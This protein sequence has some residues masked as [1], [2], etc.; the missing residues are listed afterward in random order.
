MQH[1]FFP[2][3]EDEDV[4]VEAEVQTS[5][6]DI[7]E[8]NRWRWSRL[9][10]EVEVQTSFTSYP[11][12][13]LDTSSEADAQIQTSFSSI[14]RAVEAQ[15]QTSFFSLRSPSPLESDA[16]MQTSFVEVPREIEAQVQTSLLSLPEAKEAQ[17]QTS[18]LSFPRGGSAGSLKKF[19]QAHPPYLEYL[20]KI[21]PYSA[22][23]DRQVQTA[24][25]DLPPSQVDTQV[26]T[27][28]PDYMSEK[29]D[30]S[31]IHT[32]EYLHERSSSQL[33]DVDMYPIYT[34]AEVQTLPVEIPPGNDWRSSRLRAAAQ[35]QTS[36]C[37]VKR[38]SVPRSQNIIQVKPAKLEAEKADEVARILEARHASL[39]PELT[40]AAIQTSDIQLQE[41]DKWCSPRQVNAQVQTST[42][43][44]LKK[45]SLL[46]Q[47]AK[48]D[49]MDAAS[50][51]ELL[52]KMSEVQPASPELMR[53]ASA[54]SESA[55]EDQDLSPALLKKR[56]SSAQVSPW[57]YELAQILSS[58]PRTKDVEMHTTDAQ[59]L[60]KRLSH[61]SLT[62]VSDESKEEIT[63]QDIDPQIR[64]WY[65]ELP[66][67][68]TSDPQG[69]VQKQSLWSPFVENEMQ[70][71]YI[72]MPFRHKWRS[73]HMQADHEVQTDEFASPLDE[74]RSSPQS[75]LQRQASLLEVWQARD[76]AE[77]HMQ[78]SALDVDQV[79][80]S[81]QEESSS[82][83][84]IDTQVQTSLLDIWKA[85][86]HH[87]DIQTQTSMT[88][89]LGEP[90]SFLDLWKV[91]EIENLRQKTAET[92]LL[93]S[94]GETSPVLYRDLEMKADAWSGK[95]KSDAP[96]QSSLLELLEGQEQPVTSQMDVQM[97]ASTKL[98]DLKGH[99]S[100]QNVEEANFEPPLGS[101]IDTE[102]QTSLLDMWKVKE[103][104]AQAQ[105]PWMDVA[106]TEEEASLPPGTMVDTQVQTSLLDIWRKKELSEFQ[107][108]T[109]WTDSQNLVEEPPIP[110]PP[111]KD[112]QIQ[113]SLTD[114]WRKNEV[115]DLQIQTPWSEEEEPAPEPPLY[116]DT[117]VQTS[118]G[119]MWKT[120]DLIADENQT[121]WADSVKLG[122]EPSVPSTSRIVDTQVQTSLVD[123]WKAKQLS[124]VQSQTPWAHVFKVDE[125]LPCSVASFT[126]TQVQ[127]SLTDL[128]KLKELR[129]SEMQTSLSDLQIAMEG[130]SIPS[131]FQGSVQLSGPGSAESCPPTQIDTEVQTSLT[132]I[133][134][135]KEIT[136]AN[137]QTSY[138]DLPQSTE[139]LQ[140]E[141]TEEPC[142]SNLD[143]KALPPAQHSTAQMVSEKHDP[144]SK[145]SKKE[146]ADVQEQ[147]YEFLKSGTELPS[148]SQSVPGVH[149]IQVVSRTLEKVP[150][151]QI[152]SSSQVPQLPST[153]LL[154]TTVVPIIQS[155]DAASVQL[156]TPEKADTAPIAEDRAQSPM[157]LLQQ[158][159]TRE[160]EELQKQTDNLGL[161][162]GDDLA[163]F[164][165]LE[166]GQKATAT[167]PE[168]EKV[169]QVS[170]KEIKSKVPLFTE[171]QVQT[172]YV[173]IPRGK[174]WR[175]SRL[176]TEAQVQTSFHDI[177]VKDKGFQKTVSDHAAAKK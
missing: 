71:P 101:Q 26:Q 66:E 58:S 152:P 6:T 24:N 130:A 169:E 171:A 31:S 55:I 111:F 139:T 109:P 173:E 1:L 177:H 45:L 147:G 54:L 46:S 27:T 136:D 112:T 11:F 170:K 7:P 49:S 160:E 124:Q 5:G 118:L 70:A 103:S 36:I 53:N 61:L 51:T 50:R 144:L 110:V 37:S 40:E 63:P 88:E 158:W 153:E 52:K 172:S 76:L 107:M 75:G 65:E 92:E 83:L 62:K 97:Q 149:T 47:I 156:P 9:H 104:D 127:T 90:A 99:V 17:V 131:W 69:A 125:E 121:P 122:E 154:S 12:E 48:I 77:A 93:E 98:S 64:K 89:R 78:T 59:E 95:E 161:S 39:P 138:V 142:T 168:K 84:V 159:T 34:D 123:I 57:S 167:I 157:S 86:E 82:P 29:E 87:A 119:D 128:W 114:F 32:P 116:K 155:Q 68:Q 21:G 176:C 150:D 148:S 140:I 106:K 10:N 85:K 42:I 33:S 43:E 96:V 16:Q 60:E 105:T 73:S 102:M 145:V 3:Q 79:S 67:V 151:A 166:E 143:L 133:W 80:P 18:F 8:G 162:F 20:E 91:K 175:A 22:L 28:F 2:K 117:K 38:Q 72:D 94:E 25:V 41:L 100:T 163:L 14:P 132:D 129:D 126:D 120:Q 115:A 137:T 108:Q 164:P 13:E 174:K 35:V 56:P 141:S 4:G 165:L 23:I 74:S 135:K 15:A 19:V 81:L 146:P 30:A 134:R 113:T 44:L